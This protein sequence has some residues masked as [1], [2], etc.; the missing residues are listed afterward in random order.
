MYTFC[1]QEYRSALRK[2]LVLLRRNL[3]IVFLFAISFFKILIQ[4]STLFITS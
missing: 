1:S 3:L 2:V 4:V